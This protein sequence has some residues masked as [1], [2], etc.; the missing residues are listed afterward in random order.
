MN[1]FIRK[2][3][4]EEVKHIHGL[5]K[6]FAQRG[7]ILPR[8]LTELFEHVR[9]FFVC[10]DQDN[11]S[12]IA[13]ICAMHIC[14]EDIA[15]IRSLAVLDEYRKCGIGAKLVEACLSEALTLGIYKVFVLTYEVDFF[16]RF[17]FEV[18]DKAVLPHKVWTDC[19]KCVKFPDCD[20]VAM[21]LTL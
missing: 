11:G 8:S 15:E 16:R 1:C 12:K 4:I 20:E 7:T 5:M 17:G 21:L 19:V 6:E 9:D 13:G 14:W 18:I 2:T 10:V 3:R